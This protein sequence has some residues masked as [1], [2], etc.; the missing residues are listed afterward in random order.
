MTLSDN[1]EI[2]AKLTFSENFKILG[3]F[4][5][6]E[7]GML[8]LWKKHSS[9]CLRTL[10]GIKNLPLEERRFYRKC[11]CACWVTGVHPL[12]GKYLK[13]SLQTR[14]WEVGGKIMRMLET[15]EI[16]TPNEAGMNRIPRSQGFPWEPPPRVYNGS[17]PLDARDKIELED[18][19][20]RFTYH[21]PN[22]DQAERYRILRGEALV[23]A[24]LIVQSCPSSAERSTALTH[25]DA[26]VMF[27]NAAIARQ[28]T[29]E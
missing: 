24:R 9:T 29:A 28:P 11:Q 4:I 26:C 2:H 1:T 13:Q 3:R 18:L 17:M 10:K 14:D 19:E 27:A 25:L 21:A 5:K 16:A 23:L 20:S 6:L 8:T 12:T 22:G 15:L 7:I